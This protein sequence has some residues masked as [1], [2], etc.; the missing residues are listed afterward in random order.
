[1]PTRVSS[2]NAGRLAA[3]ERLATNMPNTLRS[4]IPRVISRN[5]QVLR[6]RGPT[7]HVTGQPL[8]AAQVASI[9]RS[10]DSQPMPEDAARQVILGWGVEEQDNGELVLAK[11]PWSLHSTQQAAIEADKKHRLDQRTNTLLQINR[12]LKAIEYDNNYLA[13]LAK[14][15]ASNK[16]SNTASS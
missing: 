13:R 3:S 4:N 16:E 10:I 5:H 12:C 15:A 6:G 9:M 14:L 7:V 1:M 2:N 11:V 8:T